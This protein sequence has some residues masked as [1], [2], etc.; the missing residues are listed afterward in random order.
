MN[1]TQIQKRM[2][3]KQLSKMKNTEKITDI[4]KQLIAIPSMIL[5][6]IVLK[7]M[8]FTNDSLLSSKTVTNFI[9]NHNLELLIFYLA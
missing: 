5:A 3:L 8:I 1:R 9:D 2:K 6:Y 4:K 7:L